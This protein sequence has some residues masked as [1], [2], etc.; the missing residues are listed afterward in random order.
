MTVYQSINLS[1]CLSLH[2]SL[3]LDF[4]LRS[5]PSLSRFYSFS[6]HFF[7][8]HLDLKSQNV[9][10]LMY[11]R[12][13][14]AS[15]KEPSTRTFFPCSKAL[16]VKTFQRK[17]QKQA[18]VWLVIWERRKLQWIEIRWFK[19]FNLDLSKLLSFGSF[20]L[21]VTGLYSSNN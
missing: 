16:I 11:C 14:L 8:K 21:V 20:L 13:Q 19:I 9:F 1:N 17:K 15:L 2:L 6:L 4:T 7:L 3:C 18:W 5:P 12:Y 10:Y